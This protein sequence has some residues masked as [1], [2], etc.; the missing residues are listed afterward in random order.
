MSRSIKSA[1]HE[2]GGAQP[3]GGHGFIEKTRRRGA[4]A[5]ARRRRTWRR[6]TEGE[7]EA[8]ERQEKDRR[9]ARGKVGRT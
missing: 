7:D 2:V 3:A 5:R 8:G 9:R 1:A 6:E 4:D